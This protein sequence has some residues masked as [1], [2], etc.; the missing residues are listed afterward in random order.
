MKR[1]YKRLLIF[2]FVL[3]VLAIGGGWFALENVLPF[4]AIKPYRQ[5]PENASWKIPRGA[6]PVEYGLTVDPLVIHTSDSITLQG[7]FVAANPDSSV[8][9]TVIVLH[10]ISSCKEFFLPTAEKLSQRGINT[11]LFDLRAHGDSGGDF[12]TFGAKEKYDV[13]QIVDSLLAR[14]ST[15]RIGVM[16][17]SLGGAI[18]L[19]SLAHDPR[20]QFGV[21]EST[22]YS[23]EKVVE[24]YGENW[25]GIR[26]EWMAHEVLERSGEIACF[27]PFAVMPCEAAKEI[28]QPV[29]MSHGDRDERIPLAFGQINYNNLASE[30]KQWYTITGAG[31]NGL[32]Q[33]GGPRYVQAVVSFIKAGSGQ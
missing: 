8:N 28:E 11:V 14:D 15:M 9:T 31:H 12:C 33:T 5:T 24:Q 21:I 18:A 30:E 13:S 27:D 6:D 10:G 1:V 26:S 22:F 23:L 4:T 2:S 20:L 3:S 16:G 7:W 19:Q 29:F 25:F 32:W 17:H